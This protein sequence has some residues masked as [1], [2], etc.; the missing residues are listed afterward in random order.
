MHVRVNLVTADPVRLDDTVRYL[1][2]EVRKQVESAPGNLGTALHLN[3][4]LSVAVVESLWVS[5][6]ALRESERIAEPLRAEAARR[7][8]GTAS[9]EHFGVA[10]L[11]QVARPRAGAG[12]RLTRLDTDPT[13]IGEAIA[14]YEDTAVPWLTEVD[15]FC[16]AHLYV[17]TRSGQSISETIWRDA[18][19]LA[20]SRSAA[21]AIRADAVAATGSVVRALAEY[22]LVFTTLRPG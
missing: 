16:A 5:G 4:E 21:A 6:N 17:D 18:D 11:V 10:N 15:G 2:D 19:A 12:V 8:G 9:E 3:P 7:A 13:S 20:A 22:R 14:A 1:E